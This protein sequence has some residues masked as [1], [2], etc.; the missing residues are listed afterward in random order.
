[1]VGGNRINGAQRNAVA[2]A[3]NQAVKFLT[4][5]RKPKNNNNSSAGVTMVT[6]M[7]IPA[8]VSTVRQQ[9]QGDTKRHTM[10]FLVYRA[11]IAGFVS[12]YLNP[13]GTL[14]NKDTSSSYTWDPNTILVAGTYREYRILSA[15]IKFLGSA[16]ST[17]PGSV[18]IGGAKDP[19]TTRPELDEFTLLERSYV[20]PC[21]SPTNEVP[22][23]CDSE[24]RTI[25]T[26]SVG[27]S[28]YSDK[29]LFNSGI[30]F[31][32]T[33]ANAVDLKF[34]VMIEFEFRGKNPVPPLASITSLTGTSY[35]DLISKQVN[36][37]LSPPVNWQWKP[38]VASSG[39]YTGSGLVAGYLSPGYYMVQA[40]QKQ[41]AA[42]EIDQFITIV[43]AAGVTSETNIFFPETN[44]GGQYQGGNNYSF[45]SVF[46]RLDVGQTLV[47]AMQDGGVFGAF[48]AITFNITRVDTNTMQALA[49][50]RGFVGP[51]PGQ[52][53]I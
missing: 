9:S 34:N 5:K 46:L 22:I 13:F 8:Q 49:N 44:A 33:D 24:W 17:N 18:Y 47:W 28:S 27:S 26:F 4:K 2:V 25:K 43:N 16:P 41:V 40:F 48:Q 23:P 53:N 31:I 14:D 21:W 51:I 6:P 30:A 19:L 38:S 12:F 7:S 15:K 39:T 11:Q 50:S 42:A 52:Q 32:E 3:T 36:L 35:I 1:M 20:G 29:R 37:S 45:D 10:S